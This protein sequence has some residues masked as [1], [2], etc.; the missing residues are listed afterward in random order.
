LQELGYHPGPQ[1]AE[2]LRSVED[3]QL[4]GVIRTKEEAQKYV[5]GNFPKKK[6]AG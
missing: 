1:F 6:G 3:A 2:I 5:L 4:D